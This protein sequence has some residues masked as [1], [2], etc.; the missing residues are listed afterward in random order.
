LKIL[1]DA[2]KLFS[3]AEKLKILAKAQNLCGLAEKVES[4]GET[5]KPFRFGIKS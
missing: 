4:F 3:S 2:Q 5:S 1:A